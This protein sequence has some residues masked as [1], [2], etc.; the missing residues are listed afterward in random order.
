MNKQALDRAAQELL[1]EGV[2]LID[3]TIRLHPDFVPQLYSDDLRPQYR[4]GPTGNYRQLEFSD[5]G[6]TDE[7]PHGM[8]RF[9]FAVGVRLVDGYA[10]EDTVEQT[11]HFEI[12]ARFA[13]SYYLKDGL[14][15]KAL[16]EFANYNVGYHVWP[17]WR[18][19]VQSTCSRVGL[20]PIPVPLYKI[21]LPASKSPAS[22]KSKKPL[23]FD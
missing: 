14:D 2:Y 7:H 23:S 5:E 1:I 21:P 12:N 18:E 4:A 15:D 11:V 17:Y 20:P 6:A 9:E 3:S 19:Y 22:K 16:Q 13:A 10:E 8:V